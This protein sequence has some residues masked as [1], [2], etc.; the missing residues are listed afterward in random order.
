[1]AAQF[2][3]KISKNGKHFFTLIAANGEVILTSQMYASR[4]GA[5]KGIA[6]V[7]GNASKRS[8]YEERKGAKG[9]MHFVL[10][11]G[12]HRV[13]GTSQV[14]STPKAMEKG[15]ASVMKNGKVKRVEV[16]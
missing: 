11:A 12:N 13:I 3:L 14:Y 2:D 9:K 1:M 6:S 4:A 15:R 5:K 8:R 10:K 16:G 7:R